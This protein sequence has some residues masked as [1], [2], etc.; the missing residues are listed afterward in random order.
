[1]ADVRPAS[2]GPTLTEPTAKFGRST[3]GCRTDADGSEFDPMSVDPDV[4]IADHLRHFFA[5][6]PTDVLPIGTGPSKTA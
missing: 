2:T 1:M 4:A 3:V 6:H 5:G